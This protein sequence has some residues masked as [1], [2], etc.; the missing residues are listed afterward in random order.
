V[1]L[2][3]ENAWE[4]FEGQ[5]RP[6]LRALYGRLA[7]HPDVRTVTMSEACA[8][9]SESL[10]SIFPGSWIN[11]DFYIWIGHADDHRA[12]S[13]LAEARRT[14]DAHAPSVS[15]NALAQAREEM[16]IAEGSDWFWWYGDDH[17]SDHDLAFDDLFRRHVRNVYR[18]LE[19]PI[20]EELFVTN[21]TTQPPAMEIGRPSGLIH[22]QIDGEVTS[23][24]EWVGA[25]S[26][27]TAATA[28]AMHQVSEWSGRIALVEFGFDERH[29]YL[30]VDGTRP[31]R[32]LLAGTLGLTV[33]FLKPAGLQVVL[34]RDGKLTDVLLVKRSAKGDWDVVD[35]PG[36]ESA[37]GRIAELRVPLGCL[38]IRPSDSVAFFVTLS[39]GTVEVEQQPRHQPIEAEAPD[40][41]FAARNWTA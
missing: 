23:Y 39:E 32:E 19:A 5:G 1:I 29:L 12:W 20:P 41:R 18:A 10:T 31:M 9:A 22:P 15:E 37:I 14:L 40:G 33:R 24:F 27:E 17:S 13:Q 3:G 38:G 34:R 8:G 28:G 30:R 6:F 7:S 4:H 16:F 2:D 25:G 26:F 35:C 21:I 11:A 36:L